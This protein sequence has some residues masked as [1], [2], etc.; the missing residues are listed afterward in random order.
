[1]RLDKEVVTVSTRQLKEHREMLQ[2]VIRLQKE[3]LAQQVSSTVRKLKRSGCSSGTST[4]TP[5]AHHL[6]AGG[7]DS[8]STRWQ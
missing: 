2:E 4:W 8:T 5:A 6:A 7:V 3:N 1:M